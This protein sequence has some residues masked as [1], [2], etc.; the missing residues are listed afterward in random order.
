VIWLLHTTPVSNWAIVL[1]I[2][3]AVIRILMWFRA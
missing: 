2:A 3:T 1:L